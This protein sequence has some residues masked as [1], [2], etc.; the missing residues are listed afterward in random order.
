MKQLTLNPDELRVESFPTAQRAA[1][2]EPVDAF[3]PQT[4]CRNCP[5]PP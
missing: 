4:G 1:E 2:N 3:S 5:T